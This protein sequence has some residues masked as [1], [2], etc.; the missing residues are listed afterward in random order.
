MNAGIG[1]RAAPALG[2]GLRARTGNHVRRGDPLD[3]LGQ[4]GRPGGRP[5]R[6]SRGPGGAHRLP[7]GSASA[8]RPEGEA[9]L[10]VEALMP[11][12]D[13]PP[14]GSGRPRRACSTT[15]KTSASTTSAKSS[16]S[17]PLAGSLDGPAPAQTSAAAP[18]RGASCRNTSGSAAK[19]LRR[20]RSRRRVGPGSRDCSTPPST[21][22]RTPCAS[23]PPLGRFHARIGL[24]PPWQPA[25][26]RCLSQARR[27]DARP[28]RLP[29]LHDARRPAR[30][31]F[32][33]KPETERP[34][35]PGSSSAATA[36]SRPTAPWRSARRRPSPGRD[37]PALAPALQRPGVWYSLWPV[38]H[39]VISR[40]RSAGRS[41]C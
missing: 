38:A 19:R 23:V 35:G 29:R 26:A 41:C 18:P 33:G 12:L 5:A 37:L 39:A 14:A 10:W 15:C 20:V 4:A 13:L 16:A 11:L 30:R 40:S 21:A 25:R 1:I 28:D 8:L 31:R 7:C 32:T 6:A 9:S 2:P 24:G 22:P 34:G 36:C 3:A 27:G 17:S